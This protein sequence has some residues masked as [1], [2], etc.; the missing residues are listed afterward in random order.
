M[1]LLKKALMNIPL[2]NYAY[3]LPENRIALYPCEPR[4]A[5]KLLHFDENGKITHHQ[6]SSIVDILNEDDTLFFNDTKVIPARI[7]FQTATGAQIEI[8]LLEP[9]F[10]QK[11]ISLA[12]QAHSPCVWHCLVGNLKRVKDQILQISAKSQEVP[13]NFFAKIIARE[14]EILVEFSW[15]N[16]DLNFATVI[17]AIGKIPLPPYMKRDSN[18]NDK[19]SY[20]TVYSKNEGAVAAPTAGLHFT[21][22]VFTRLRAKNIRDFYLTLHVSSGTFMPVKTENA[23]AHTM[24][25]EQITITKS[26]ITQILASKRIIPVGTTSMRTLE[27][28]YWYG[29]LLLEDKNAIFYIPQM[30]PYEMKDENIGLEAAMRAVLQKMAADKTEILQG[31]TQIYIFPSYRFRVCQGIITNFHQPK[32]TLLLL[33]SAIIGDAWKEIYQAALAHDY[34]FLSYGDSSFLES[35]QKIMR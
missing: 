15:D 30:L 4:D 8:F 5:S 22:N 11:L 27:S 25:E 14:P 16:D 6:F 23:L 29:R 19:S 35:T 34:R 32:S 31:S 9:S 20:Q 1:A 3:P 17:E 18:E 2:E 33:I 21:E 12:M 7:F 13:F 26:L 28:I 24:H 10:P